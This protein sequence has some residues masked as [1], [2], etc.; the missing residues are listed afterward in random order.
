MGR[1]PGHLKQIGSD[2]SGPHPNSDEH[3]REHTRH[4]HPDVERLGASSTI[5]VGIPVA[6]GHAESLAGSSRPVESCQWSSPVDNG[7][8][9]FCGSRSQAVDDDRC[10]D[11]APPFRV[12]AG[13][14]LLARAI[15]SSQVER[16]AARAPRVP[17]G[18][19]APGGCRQLRCEV[20]MIHLVWGNRL[21]DC[22]S[23]PR[24]G[25]PVS[26]VCRKMRPLAPRW[27]PNAVCEHHQAPRLLSCEIQRARKLGKFLTRNFRPV[28]PQ[29][30]QALR[31]LL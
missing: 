15:A 12:P 29:C 10:P 18:S 5:A 24:E 23:K 7:D 3:Q 9:M 11:S 28:A 22:G 16:L 30:F 25:P 4:P 8:N 6:A 17:L 27:F 13:G 14:H 1:G 2:L 26:F 21:I 19:T 31:E 20:N